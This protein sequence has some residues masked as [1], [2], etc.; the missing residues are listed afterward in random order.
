MFDTVLS[1]IKDSS[2][3]STASAD[4]VHDRMHVKAVPRDS[5]GNLRHTRLRDLQVQAGQVQNLALRYDYV[6]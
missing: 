5:A 1:H 6:N 3:V 4:G 2:F